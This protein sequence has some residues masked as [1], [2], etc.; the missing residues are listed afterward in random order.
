MS[1]IEYPPGLIARIARLCEAQPDRESCGFVVRQGRA[2]DVVQIPNVADRYHQ[3]DPDRFPRTSRESYYMD[4]GA[5][6]RLHEQLARAGGDSVAVWHSH[7]EAGAYFS[8]K[9]RADAL[10]DGR[11]VLPGAEYLVFSVRGGRAVE[12]R[13]FRYQDGRFVEADLCTW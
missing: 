9:D 11:Q 10:L 13:R 3:A 1:S 5:L 6:L 8:E 12:G 4:G 7:V 2:L